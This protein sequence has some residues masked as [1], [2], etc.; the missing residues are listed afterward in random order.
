M[1]L[2][3]NP[4]YDEGLADLDDDSYVGA[5]REYLDQTIVQSELDELANKTAKL[6]RFV[7][8]R[9]AHHDEKKFDAI[10]KYRDLDE[11][12]DFLGII[13]KK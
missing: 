8:K 10:P 11:A 12:I 5:G 6:K 4:N 7:N 9:V 13:H 3:L 1:A 2:R